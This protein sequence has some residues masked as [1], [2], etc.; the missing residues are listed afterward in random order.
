MN[1]E[2]TT[3]KK[4]LMKKRPHIL[5]F[6]LYEISSVRTGES[7]GGVVSTH[8]YGVSFGDGENVLKLDGC[9]G[10]TTLWVH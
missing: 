8:G 6:C 5:W 10:H 4:K 1:L 2:N 7:R 9:D 3:I